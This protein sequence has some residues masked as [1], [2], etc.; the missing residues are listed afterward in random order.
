MK[1]NFDFERIWESKL[2][3]R[4]RLATAPIMEKLRML[5]ALHERAVAIRGAR[6]LEATAVREKPGRYG[7]R[8][9]KTS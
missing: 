4:Q 7:N 8:K 1:N 5:D 9:E 2:A 6:F 3:L